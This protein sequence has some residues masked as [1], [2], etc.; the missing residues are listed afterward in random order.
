MSVKLLF[1]SIT[2]YN[3]TIYENKPCLFQVHSIDVGG[4]AIGSSRNSSSSPCTNLTTSSVVIIIIGITVA[5]LADAVVLE[6]VGI[7][8]QQTG[9]AQNEKGE[10]SADP[11]HSDFAISTSLYSRYVGRQFASFKSIANDG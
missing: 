3:A 1:L 11:H 4:D 9:K 8:A 2:R 5:L 6:L 10:I 7:D